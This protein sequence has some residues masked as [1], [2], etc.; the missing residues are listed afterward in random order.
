MIETE[1]G[2]VNKELRQDYILTNNILS[3]PAL[4]LQPLHIRELVAKENI[5]ILGGILEEVAL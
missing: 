5:S 2:T 3:F 1:P 4:H